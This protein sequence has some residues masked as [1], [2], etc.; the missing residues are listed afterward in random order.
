MLCSMLLICK[1][2]DNLEK[3]RGEGPDEEGSHVTGGTRVS[4]RITS[5][6]DR[7]K[8]V[9]VPSSKTC[10]AITWRRN[11]FLVR[12]SVVFILCCSRGQNAKDQCS[13][14]VEPGY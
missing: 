7:L 4:G 13:R 1:D 3:S 8:G 2:L 5:E 14:K 12:K 10:G 6:E 9:W 11:G